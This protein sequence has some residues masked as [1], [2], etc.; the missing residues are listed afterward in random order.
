MPSKGFTCITLRKDEYKR[1]KA[2]AEPKSVRQFILE[3]TENYY[4]LKVHKTA[5]LLDIDLALITINS[6]LNKLQNIK[7]WLLNP[8]CHDEESCRAYMTFR[9][10]DI[11]DVITNLL[12]AKETLEKLREKL[13]KD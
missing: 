10:A 4:T 9:A 6:Q 8:R 13:E 11:S 12:E 5:L 3:A 7:Q 2:Y 1:I